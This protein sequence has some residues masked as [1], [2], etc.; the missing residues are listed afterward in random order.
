MIVKMPVPPEPDV[1]LLHPF[2]PKSLSE[3]A[4]FL[5]LWCPSHLIY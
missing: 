1:T 2:S 5:L 3:N 4:T